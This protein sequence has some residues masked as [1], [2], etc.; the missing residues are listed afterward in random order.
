MSGN[1]VTLIGNLSRD[2]ELRFTPAGA[3]VAN[4]GLAVNRVWFDADRQKQEEVSFF[5]VTV[6]QQL[7]E[8]VCESLGKGDRVHVSGRIE[9]QSWESPTGEKRNKVIVVADE[10]G[11]SLRWATAQVVKNERR[12]G[13]GAPARDAPPDYGGGGDYDSSQEPF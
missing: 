3:A 11:P 5:D 12:G 13:D 6:W 2:P 1:D 9:Q 8:N 4:F 7:A 10:V